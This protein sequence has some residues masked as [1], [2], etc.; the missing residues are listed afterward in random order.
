MSLGI[1][2]PVSMNAQPVTTAPQISCRWFIG[3]IS[4]M[5]LDR[6]LLAFLCEMRTDFG[7][8]RRGPNQCECENDKKRP[9]VIRIGE[10]SHFVHRAK[11]RV[12]Y[13]MQGLQQAYTRSIA[14]RP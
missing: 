10:M 13:G 6:H 12:R 5:S 7:T 3:Q 2:D 4:R 8:R 14:K 9:P 1:H 11:Q